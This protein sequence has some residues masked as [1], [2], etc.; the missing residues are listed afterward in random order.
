M[1][2]NSIW[3]C[4]SFIFVLIPDVSVNNISVM[5]RFFYIKLGAI[6]NFDN[7]EVAKCQ[8]DAASGLPNPTPLL[9][10]GR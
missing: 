1:S 5:S 9:R 8:V 6:E 10:R 2:T 4:I 7:F 3:F